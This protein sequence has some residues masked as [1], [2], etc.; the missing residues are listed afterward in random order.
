VP[1]TE[2]LLANANLDAIPGIAFRREGK[3]V[4]TSPAKPC[5]N[6]DTLPFPS[7]DSIAHSLAQKNYV[8]VS[9]SRGC[10]G[11]CAY[12]S[13]YSFALTGSRTSRWRQRSLRNIVDEIALLHNEHGVSHF[14]FVDDSFIEPPR[15]E[16]WAQDFRDALAERRLTIKFRTQVR[17]DR[18]TPGLVEALR[19]AGW[20]STSLGVEN[21]AASALKRM[22]KSASPEDNL[23]ALEM[24]TQNGIYVTMG[25]ILFDP[26]TTMDELWT[27]LE[28]LKSHPWPVTKGVFTEMYAAQGTPFTSK[29]DRRGLLSPTDGT[30]SYDIRDQ[31]ARRAYSLLKRWHRSH[32]DT[33]DWVIDSLT[34]PKVLPD[35]GYDGTYALYQRLRELDL[36]F[37]SKALNHVVGNPGGDDEVS[38]ESTESTSDNFA[39]I[40][41]EIGSLYALYGLKREATPNPFIGQ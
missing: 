36:W 22:G 27:N 38:M 32:C 19:D 26:D 16:R 24:L 4:R 30:N 9:T 11:H 41:K 2:A 23:E 31:Q 5:Q 13:I 29:L 28:F 6:L 18:L 10:L 20:F 8:H 3:L 12:C 14:K 34:A 25:M 39:S 15:D 35:E 21:A 1:L 33:Y 7:R 37:F 40:A 17:S